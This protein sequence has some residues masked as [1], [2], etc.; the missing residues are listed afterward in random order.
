VTDVQNPNAAGGATEWIFAS[1]SAN[2]I[3]T[4]CAGGCLFNFNNTPW[5]P[6]TAYALGQEVLDTHFQIQVVTTAGTSGSSTPAWSTIARAT[7]ND[8]TVKWFNQG[9]ATQVT[10]GVWTRLT[11]FPVGSTILDSNNNIELVTTSHGSG[12]SGGNQPVWNTTVGGTTSD[13]T[14]TWTNIGKVSA[15]AVASAGGASGVI[16]DNFVPAGT[17]AGASQ[18]YFSTLSNQNCGSSGTGGCAIQAS[19]A[20]LK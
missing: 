8:G 11:H 1:A 18:I 4:A 7:T 9:L 10:T 12:N 19:Q 15:S 2:G 14:L 20:A 13:S 5:Q 3:A 16:I 17:L 6:S